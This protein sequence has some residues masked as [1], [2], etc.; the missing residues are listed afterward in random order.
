[1][2]KHGS[3]GD[4]GFDA[5]G[6]R[7]RNKAAVLFIDVVGYSAMMEADENATHAQWMRARRT[8][9][10]PALAHHN[11]RM[12]KSTGDGLLATFETA[13]GAL[14]CTFDVHGGFSIQSDDE[15]RSMRIRA[16]LNMVNYIAEADDIYGEGVNIA[17]RL[18]G[19][20]DPGGTVVTSTFEEAARASL[21]FQK[22]DLGFLQ[23]R[24]IE[25]R[26]R[27]YKV[28]KP[29]QPPPTTSSRQSHHPSIAVLPMKTIGLDET[30][31]Y[32]ADSMVYEI[33]SLLSSL[34]EV[35]VISSAT[36]MNLSGDQTDRI[37]IAAQLGVQY[38]LMGRIMKAGE[39]LHV[40]VELSDTDRNVVIWTD[41][42]EF[43]PGRLFDVQSR[44]AREVSYALLPRI[45][46]SEL[47]RFSEIPTEVFDAYGC[48]IRGMYH[49]YRLTKADSNQAKIFLDRALELD[50]HFAD[51]HALTAK[52][53]ILRI[54]ENQSSNPKDD[55]RKAL[56]HARLA[57][58]SDSTHSMALALYGHTLSFLF[59]EYDQALGA[60]ETALA[61]SPNS[62]IAWGLSA[63]TF[64][65]LGQGA[66]AIA[67]GRHALA[68][69]PLEP[70]A[71]FY[72]SI[73][74]TAHYVNEDYEDAVHWGWR[75][76][77][78]AP[79]LMPNLR[80]LAAALAAN[81]EITDAH[82][83]SEEILK[84]DPSFRVGS[85]TAWYP[86]RDSDLLDRLD[87]H[88]RAAGLPA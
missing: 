36:T 16:S 76:F 35:F 48:M 29:D 46:Q 6:F 13:R 39:D 62:A 20:S 30:D 7:G 51:A 60:F 56:E 38:L 43:G 54:G 24:N 57:L 34:H 78:S 21:D 82:R 18:L 28:A 67:R 75:T 19:F 72:R 25:R 83:I 37:G 66:E 44:I 2:D 85:F 80:G 23:L 63:P 52:W 58:K 65:Y 26:V 14:G 59:R 22:A 5:Y 49:L 86:I 61:T 32:L 45:R 74:T 50:P 70:F 77:G 55:S 84:L 41:R 4:D 27:A 31:L 8:I 1:M 3:V 64:C 79:T 81:G 17:A 42:F 68:L 88:L 11:G 33:V 53:Y 9:I 87:A 15:Q 73:L 47:N 69:S 71:Y 12:I 40:M 10:E